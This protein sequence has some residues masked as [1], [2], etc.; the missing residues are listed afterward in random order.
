MA[1]IPVPDQTRSQHVADQLASRLNARPAR[2]AGAVWAVFR[3]ELHPRSH[4]G[5]V[6]IEGGR[7]ALADNAL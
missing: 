6:L 7:T 3:H 1:G 2:M 5:E 4:M